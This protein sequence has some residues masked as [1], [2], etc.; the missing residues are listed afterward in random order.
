MF[1]NRVLCG[2]SFFRLLTSSVRVWT[3]VSRARFSTE[4]HVSV[5][6]VDWSLFVSRSMNRP[7]Y[8]AL[9]GVRSIAINMSVYPSVCLSVCLFVCLFVC[10]LAYLKIRTSK[11]YQILCACHLWQWYSFTIYFLR[12]R[13]A[14]TVLMCR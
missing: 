9:L 4:T 14:Y 12:H 5:V 8:F 6:D 7:R 13:I 11:F 3:E 1:C 10:P 2:G